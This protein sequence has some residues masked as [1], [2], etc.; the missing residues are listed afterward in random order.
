[1]DELKRKV[2]GILDLDSPSNYEDAD[3]AIESITGEFE[4]L[5]DVDHYAVAEIVEEWFTNGSDEEN[6]DED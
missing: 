3:A 1:M 6:E 5:S 4:E 2:L